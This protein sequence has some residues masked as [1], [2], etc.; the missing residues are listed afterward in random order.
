[1]VCTEPALVIEEDFRSLGL[2]P[3][4]MLAILQALINIST[5]NAT[6]TATSQTSMEN[7]NIISLAETHGQETML[8]ESNNASDTSDHIPLE[9]P[10]TTAASPLLTSAAT[11]T[12]ICIKYA[13][14]TSTTHSVLTPV[15][16]PTDVQPI[17]APAIVTT[18]AV[19][20]ADV[21]IAV[22]TAD[23]S[24]AVPTAAATFTTPAVA[25][26]ITTPIFVMPIVAT[27]IS[28][29]APMVTYHLPAAEA[30]GPYYCVMCRDIGVFTGW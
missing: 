19:S 1:M 12:L 11:L 27:Q 23:S 8:S 16:N 9:T 10:T 18:T 29:T 26:V 24:V 17:V 14:S 3:G 7:F 25:A 5:N 2:T 13:I 20:T 21:P 30:P 4:T 22:P 15:V 28:M 6:T